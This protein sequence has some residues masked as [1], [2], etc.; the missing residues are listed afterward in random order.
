MIFIG[1]ENTEKCDFVRP[2]I[3]SFFAGMFMVNVEA[4]EIPCRMSNT[5]NCCNSKLEN[6]FVPNEI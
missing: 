4:H 3:G 5:V 6:G 2:R 1:D